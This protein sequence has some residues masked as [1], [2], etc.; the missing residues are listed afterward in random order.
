MLVMMDTTT[1]AT[2]RKRMLEKMNPKLGP[3][4]NTGA[5]PKGDHPK[6][7]PPNGMKP[8]KG[9]TGATTTLVVEVRVLQAEERG[10][11]EKVRLLRST[12]HQV[13]TL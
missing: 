13:S 1:E 10:R 2:T 11:K 4:P 5:N 8:P 3:N 9:I 6:P 7:N 12:W